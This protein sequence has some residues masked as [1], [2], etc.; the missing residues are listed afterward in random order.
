MYT[1]TITGASCCKQQL[2]SELQDITL[3]VTVSVNEVFVAV[4]INNVDD[5]YIVTLVKKIKNVNALGGP[6]TMVAQTMAVG[7]LG[8]IV[9]I[10]LELHR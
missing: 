10:V 8:Q 3:P 7:P 6:C 5:E 1:V 4:S 2:L 9:P